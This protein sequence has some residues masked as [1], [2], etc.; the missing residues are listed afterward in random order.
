MRYGKDGLVHMEF[1][2]SHT[3][4]IL[5]MQRDLGRSNFTHDTKLPYVL[6]ET[7]R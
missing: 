5:F 2:A 1:I 3:I 6:S 7:R 4:L